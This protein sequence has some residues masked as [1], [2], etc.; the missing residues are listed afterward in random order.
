MSDSEDSTVT[1][2]KD[3]YA[4]AVA[5]FQVPPSLDY[6]PVL[7]ELDQA[8]PFPNFVLEHVYP[9][10]MPSEDEVFP[11]EEQPLP[12]AVSPTTDSPGYITYSDPEE[13][14]TDYPADGGDDNDDDG[15]SD[16]DEDDD[17]VE[18]DEEE[19]EDEE[20]EHLASAYSI[21]PSPVHRTTARIS[22]P[23]CYDLAESRDT[24]YFPSTTI[25]YITSGTPPLLPIH[26][27][28]SSP[29]MLLPST[30]HKV[31]VLEV[32]LP[33]QKRLRIA[34][35]LR[36]EVDESSS[37]PTARPTRGFRADYG[38]VGTLDD[39]IRRD[40]KREDTDEIYGRLDDAQDDR[41]LMSGQLNMLRKDRR[42]HAWTAR[43]MESEARLS[44]EA[45]VQ[46]MDASDTVRAEVMSLRVANA[47]ATRDT[48]RS[49]NGKDSH[50]PGMGA[51]RQASPARECTYQDFMKFKPLYFKGTEGVVE[52]TQWFERM[53][54]VF[55]ISNCNVDNQIKFA[56][57]TLFGSALMWWN[58]HV[59]TVGP[60]VA[61]AMTWTN[62]KK[63][64][65]DKYCP[66]DEIKKLEM[67]KKISTFAERQDENKRKFEDTSKNNPNQQQNKRRNTGMAYTTG[68]G[69][70]KP[71][72]GSKPMCSKCNYHMTDNV[73]QNATSATGLAIWPVIVRV[74]QMPNLLTTKRALGLVRKSLALSVEPRDISRGSV[75]SLRI[76]TMESS[77]KWK[78]SSKS[79]CGMLMYVNNIKV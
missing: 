57:C 28:T 9:E 75:Q 46:S 42:A 78:C 17:D 51:R 56:T 48:D 8:P 39:E 36:F 69:E 15:S 55:R 49:R 32:T 2:T 47:L 34:L 29:P 4:Y 60:D 52:L 18:E 6:V 35:G 70:K 14:P 11:A 65:T 33:P 21:P 24:I 27:P 30:S 37:T 3:P 79:V 38:F 1:H 12:T 50:D 53:E 41:V 19:D 76:T 7:E 22:I 23:S 62:L 58:S 5:A 66:R 73:L 63:K 68:S 71:Y 13:D 74:L 25:K 45:W 64:M 67:D 54:T 61:Y 20:E 16:Y 43:L 59:M 40:P 77:W 31:D 44:R 10:F 72:R 26:L